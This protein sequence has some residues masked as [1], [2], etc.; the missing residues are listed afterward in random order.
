M[1]GKVVLTLQPVASASE[2]TDVPA[3]RVCRAS[4]LLLI[5]EGLLELPVPAIQPSQGRLA[6]VRP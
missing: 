2:L 3:T 5:E 6:V 1:H 4:T